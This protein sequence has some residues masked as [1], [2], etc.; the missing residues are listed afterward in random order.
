MGHWIGLDHIDNGQS[1]MASSMDNSRCIDMQTVNRLL[2]LDDRVG[3]LGPPQA[4][5][6]RRKRGAP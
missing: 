4:F 1:L 6:M 5:T 3:P 2:E